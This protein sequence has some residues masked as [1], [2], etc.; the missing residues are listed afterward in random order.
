MNG[1][2]LVQSVADLP[3]EDQARTSMI[4]P[5][6][7]KTTRGERG[8]AFLVRIHDPSEEEIERVRSLQKMYDCVMFCI[9]DS[10]PT[11]VLAL[12]VYSATQR[13]KSCLAMVLPRSSIRKVDVAEARGFKAYYSAYKVEHYG[14]APG[15]RV[16]APVGIKRR[17]PCILD[18]CACGVRSCPNP[19][20]GDCVLCDCAGVEE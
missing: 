17:M 3:Q 11:P 1:P 10:R 12:M 9:M 16:K 7:T 6:T 2:S 20:S 8:R 5:T 18:P 19:H 4:A 15:A 13:A 14:I